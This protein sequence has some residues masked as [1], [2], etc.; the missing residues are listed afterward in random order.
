MYTEDL[1]VV[2]KNLILLP[3]LIFCPFPILR[4]PDAGCGFQEPYR[5]LRISGFVSC[6]MF[7]IPHEIWNEI[8]CARANLHDPTDYNS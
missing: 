6:K 2:L 5:S 8:N 1:F 4:M 7:Q 3:P